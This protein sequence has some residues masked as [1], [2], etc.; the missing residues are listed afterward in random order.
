ME[1]EIF[2]VK[3]SCD[4]LFVFLLFFSADFD[5]IEQKK[6]LNLFAMI[7][8]S[9]VILSFIRNELV[10]QELELVA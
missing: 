8:G 9:L 5:P 6:L 2:L 1:D 10:N 4:G 7:S 3:Y